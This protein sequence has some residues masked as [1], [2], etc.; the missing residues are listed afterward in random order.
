MSV[1]RIMT[2]FH[3]ISEIPRA[4]YD[5]KRISDFIVKFGKDLNL[6]TYQDEH[7]NVVIRKPASKGYED[8]P[9]VL[10]QAHIDMVA[11][12]NKDS[13]HNFDTDPLELRVVDGILWANNTTLGADDGVGVVYM[14]ALLEDENAQHPELECVFTVLEEVGLI[15]ATEF[16]AT[17]LKASLMVGL[18]SSGENEVYVSSSGGVRGELACSVDYEHKHLSTVSIKIRGLKGGHSGGEIDQERGN[19]L[20]IAGIIL[21]R[22]LDEFDYHIVSIDGGLKL[23]AICREADVTI[24]LEDVDAFKEWFNH[25]EAEFI[26]QYEFSDNGL[27]F[28]LEDGS[29]DSVLTA[30]DTCMIADVLFMLPYGVKQKSKAIENLVITSSN[31]GTVRLDDSRFEVCVSLR[32]TQS[33]VIETVMRE[34]EWIGDILGLDVTF[35]AKYPG[36]NY[37]SGSKFR[38]K[39]KTVYQA[40]RNEPMAEVATHGGV[41]L[42]IFKGKMPNLDI[43]SLGPKMYDIHTPNEHLDVASFERTYEVLAALLASL[44]TWKVN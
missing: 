35:S 7:L 44:D 28:T 33:F 37:D 11:E 40:L 1:S 36:W 16:D 5:E 27:S 24:A 6:E 12:K 10:L 23:N 22:A 30:R 20:K 21:R 34:V 42:G 3:L 14:L 19:A 8:A 2:L 13:L 18:D 25:I 31:I 4:S 9:V 15:G 38:E 43:I 17:S 26:T 29:T 41:E 32:A 39:L